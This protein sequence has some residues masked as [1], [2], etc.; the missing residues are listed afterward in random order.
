MMIG[1]EKSVVE[2][3]DPIFAA[4]APGRGDI[5]PTP[6]REKLGGT[7]EEGYLHCGPNGAGH[8]DK[9]AGAV[10]AAV[11][12]TFFGRTTKLLATRSARNIAAAWGQSGE[13]GI[14]TLNHVFFASAHH[15]EAQLP[16]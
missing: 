15:T 8:F 16:T 11:Q 14:P 4:L 10:R 2:H 5:P 6:G 13:D 1:G 7:A 12:V 9:M 3:L